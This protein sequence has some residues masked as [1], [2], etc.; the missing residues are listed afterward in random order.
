MKETILLVT[1]SKI[2]IK[3]LQKIFAATEYNFVYVEIGTLALEIIKKYLPNL[4]IID[5]KLQEID[6]F[7]L[8]RKLKANAKTRH[9][10]VI[11]VSEN[12]SKDLIEETV[13]SGG[14][15]F[16]LKGIDEKIFI[17]K[18]KKFLLRKEKVKIKKQSNIADY[19]LIN[20]SGDITTENAEMIKGVLLN[21]IKNGHLNLIL[22]MSKVTYINSSGIGVLVEALQHINKLKG[23]LVLL[24]LREKVKEIFKLTKL[25]SIFKTVNSIF[26]V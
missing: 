18:I 23:D 16:I 15:D 19:F 10:P 25:D 4:V 17:E 20:L 14:N 21:A 11:F 8:C 2:Y 9:I 5:V 24:N 12:I 13:E 1:N 22:D 6:P 7:K 3:T 26:E